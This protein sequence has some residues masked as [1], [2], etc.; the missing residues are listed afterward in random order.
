MA[1]ASGPALTPA[2]SI[3][4]VFA[5][6]GVFTPSFTGTVEVL[7]VAG[8]GGGGMDMG[9]GGGGGGVISNTRVSVTA[10]S[11]ITVT[12]GAGGY[13]A[14]A[15]SGGY[16]TD[17]AGP[18][19][20][21]HQFTISATNGTNSV[22]GSL[23]AIG[24]GF[25][26]SSYFGY[27]PNYGY[28]N[29][30]GSGGGASGY[31]DG[32]TGRGAAGTSGQGNA[33]GGS[34]GQ[35][36]SGGGGGAGTAG[37]G[38][39]NGNGGAGVLNNILNRNLFWAGGGGGS[40]YSNSTGGLGGIGGGGGG[41]LGVTPG[42]VG[43]YNGSPG[44]GGS[45]GMWA[46]T[47]GGNGGQNT[48]GGGGGGSHYNATNK[49]G[50]GGSGI[51]I[52][53][54]LASLGT[55]TGGSPLELADLKFCVDPGNQLSFKGAVATNQ[56]AVPTPDGSNN[57]AFAV[58][59]TGTFQRVYSGT[60]G[61]YTI[62]NNDVIYRYDLVAAGGCYYH[63][64]DSTINAGQSVTFTFD[65]YISP[66]AGGYPVTNLL[67]NLEGVVGGAAADPTPTITGVWKTATITSTAGS[68]GLCRM[69]LYPGA[70]NG[71]SLAT[72]GFIL[73][74][75]PQALIGP[76][77][78]TTAPFVGP[79]GARSSTQ[80]LQD[81]TGI[82]AVTVN[83]LTYNS[84]GTSYTFNGSNNSVM[85]TDLQPF[86]NNMTWEAWV[87][88]EQ[89][90]STFNMFMGRF[91]PYFSFYAGVQLYFSNQ[92]AGAQQ[93]IA[94]AGNLSLNTW[95]MATFTTSF[96]GTNTTMKIFTN[97]VETATGTFAGSQVNSIG[98]NFMIGDGNNGT[99]GGSAWYPFKG[100]VS[101]V[102]VYERTLSASEIQ[103]NFNATRGRYGV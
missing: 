88:C 80:A 97:G 89:N 54:Y 64:N 12:V 36:Y 16:R 40:A 96:D 14:P 53:R 79:Y 55:S 6:S 51:V 92:I 22:F 33:G 78:N 70:C 63:G 4:R 94:T 100:S 81:L 59:G 18:Q 69:L 58:Q 99:N 41:A 93:T 62:T 21:G 61:G 31:S 98:T 8:G 25:G 10:G 34:V 72:S 44:G 23:T 17:G 84:T 66:G 13:G 20:S 65:Y 52:V 5:T 35:Y 43:Y 56:F 82:N 75:N 42:G 26:G 39:G 2:N 102:N 87:N 103:Q 7:V 85:S 27:T 71:T 90:V 74:R 46:N 48:G 9:G 83:S 45:P 3:V 30:G 32:N 73:Y 37:S 11:P 29:T 86:G 15:G 38:N 19:P 77:S 57:V 95:Y 76:I 50:E 47:P 49:G 67:A 60:F 68:T 1:I 24:G 101:S 28:G 91:L